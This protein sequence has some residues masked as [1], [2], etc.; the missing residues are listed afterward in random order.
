[1]IENELVNNH[2]KIANVGIEAMSKGGDFCMIEQF[3]VGFY[4]V[5]LVSE[6]A[7][8]VSKNND[9]EQYIWESAAGFSFT[10]DGKHEDHLL[11]E[12]GP[13]RVL[14]RLHHRAVR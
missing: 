3:G 13:V 4:V 10:S 12:A 11:L 6:K 5:H 14:H 9:D 1:M 2:G 7:R 8:V